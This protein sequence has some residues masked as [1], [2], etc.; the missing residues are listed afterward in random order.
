MVHQLQL[1]GF[2]HGGES[3]ELDAGIGG[4]ELPI[5]ADLF[6]VAGVFLGG[7]FLGQGGQIGD[8]AIKALA[9]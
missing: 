9:A 8:A 6:G 2:S 5:D 1:D 3:F 4:G 7:H